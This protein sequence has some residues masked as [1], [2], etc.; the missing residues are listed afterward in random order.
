M[1]AQ[2]KSGVAVSQ[3]EAQTAMG[4]VAGICIITG[5]NTTEIEVDVSALAGKYMNIY[6]EGDDA[7]YCFFDTASAAATRLVLTAQ[8]TVTF[9]VPGRL[10]QGGA[11]IDRVV[12]KFQTQVTVVRVRSVTGV[13]T[14]IRFIRA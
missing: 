7:Y 2:L 13:A 8:S 4:P 10:A 3:G 9:G 6:C 14:T 1:T 11:G 12:P 5:A